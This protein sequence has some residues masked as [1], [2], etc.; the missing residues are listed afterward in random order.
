MTTSGARKLTATLTGALLVL[1]LAACGGDDPA[2]TDQ[3]AQTSSSPTSSAPSPS[4]TPTPS[5]S[6]RPLSRFEDEPTVKVARKWA[7]GAARATTA[8][9][10]TVQAIRPFVTGAGLKRMQ[11]Y[12][13]E[14]MG[15]LYPGPI[16]FTPVGVRDQGGSA[17]VPT[18]MWVGGFTLD[19]KTKQPDKAPRIIAMDFQLVRQAGAWRI[20][21]MLY[22]S[23][24]CKKSVVKGRAF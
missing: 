21:D 20:D 19:P 7:I 15:R 4:Q 2:A 5:P 24:D 9:D 18:C 8:N 1:G 13:S 17:V 6:L 16:P 3:P 14:D 10:K 11:G 22:G 23:H 12:L